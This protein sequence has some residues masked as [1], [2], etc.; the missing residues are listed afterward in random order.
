MNA[1]GLKLSDLTLALEMKNTAPM[2]FVNG[3]QSTQYDLI[4]VPFGCFHLENQ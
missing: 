2:C 4:I 3:G 1:T